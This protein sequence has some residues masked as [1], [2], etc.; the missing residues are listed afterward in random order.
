LSHE[1]RR[2]LS[3]G[4][5]AAAVVNRSSRLRV[6]ASQL[7]LRSS[8]IDISSHSRRSTRLTSKKFGQAELHCD[9]AS[10]QAPQPPQ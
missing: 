3:A 2:T 6:I 7:M 5:A 4:N 1:A 8:L 10:G 9:E